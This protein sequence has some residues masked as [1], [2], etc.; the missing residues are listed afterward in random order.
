[1]HWIGEG[2]LG[3]TEW[4]EAVQ[5]W[6]GRAL[7]PAM[8][9]GMDSHHVTASRQLQHSSVNE[10]RSMFI[11]YVGHSFML[12]QDRH[13]FAS[14]HGKSLHSHLRVTKLPALQ[15]LAPRLTLCD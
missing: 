10:R 12:Y 13:I 15:T 4:F 1:M 5:D 7:L 8:G 11:L 9:A 2:V 14:T 3:I 6:H